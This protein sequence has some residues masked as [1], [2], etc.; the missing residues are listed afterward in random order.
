MHYFKNQL[1]FPEK[2]CFLIQTRI[3]ERT[4]QFMVV[5]ILYTFLIKKDKRLITE[6]KYP[7]SPVTI[8]YNII[9]YTEKMLV[10]NYLL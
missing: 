4:L 8:I 1:R 9:T 7:L 6:T 10:N 2:T 3:Q 5:I